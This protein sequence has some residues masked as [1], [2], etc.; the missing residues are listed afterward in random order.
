MVPPVLDTIY[1]NI[2]SFHYHSLPKHFRGCYYN[3]M[4]LQ[5]GFS[6]A[7]NALNIK[8]IIFYAYFIIECFI[9]SIESLVFIRL[10]FLLCLQ[11]KMFSECFEHFILARYDV[12]LCIHIPRHNLGTFF[13]LQQSR[14]LPCFCSSAK[15]IK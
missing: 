15:N 1:K 3:L 11:C 7:C 12:F 14:T 9:Y 2:C 8:Y 13:V 5:F 6:M 4:V 10:R